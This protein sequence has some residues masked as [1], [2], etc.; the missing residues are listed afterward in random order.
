MTENPLF[1]K[2]HKESRTIK[3]HDHFARGIYIILLHDTVS[4]VET[5]IVHVTRPMY[6][7]HELSAILRD[8]SQAFEQAKVWSGRK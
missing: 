7:S 5:E 3:A 4:Y 6:F 1:S 2:G 8:S